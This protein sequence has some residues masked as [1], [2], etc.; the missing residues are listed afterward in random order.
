MATK[1]TILGEQPIE[2]EKKKIEFTHYLGHSHGVPAVAD[3]S[4]FSYPKK[5]TDYFFI[6]LVSR[7]YLTI[8]DV[9]YD[10]MYAYTD[11]TTRVGTLFLGHFNDGIV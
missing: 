1:V 6:E 5:P 2:Q 3:L 4:T 8:N 9:S 7:K 10:L 11:T